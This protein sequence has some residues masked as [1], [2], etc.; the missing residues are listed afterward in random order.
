MH[1]PR[2]GVAG[3]ERERQ[4]AAA[5]R[6]EHESRSLAETAA[7]VQVPAAEQFVANNSSGRA[8]GDLQGVAPTTTSVPSRTGSGGRQRRGL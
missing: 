3:Q 5:S 2:S 1:S 7:F 8:C 4:L 6:K